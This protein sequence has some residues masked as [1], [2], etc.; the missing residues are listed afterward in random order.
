MQGE[1]DRVVPLPSSKSGSGLV[2]VMLQSTRY[3]PSLCCVVNA[4]SWIRPGRRG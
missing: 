1:V 4:L 3:P 2:T